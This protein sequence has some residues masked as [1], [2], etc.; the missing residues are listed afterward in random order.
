M[1]KYRTNSRVV[2]KPRS[3]GPHVIWR[4]I[5]CLMMILIP[6]IS[7]ASG[8]QTVKYGLDN[9]WTI[10]YQL[11]GTPKLPDL[12]YKSS[13]LMTIFGPLT[14]IKDF[15]AYA[16]VSLLYMVL[17]GGTVSVIYSFVYQMIGPS[18]Y[19]PTDAPPPKIKTKKYTR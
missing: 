16:L 13:G 10:P 9:G 5:G 6:A 2:Q 7:I 17:I 3:E 11:L 12:F 1:G 4:G 19:G 18:R 8:I 15:Y 14:T